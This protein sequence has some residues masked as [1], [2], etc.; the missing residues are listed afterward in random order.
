MRVYWLAVFSVV[1]GYSV[2]FWTGTFEATSVVDAEVRTAAVLQF[3]LI[4]ICKYQKK[5]L[6]ARIHL[7]MNNYTDFSCVYMHASVCG[8]RVRPF[9]C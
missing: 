6:L 5:E 3:T 2:C 7:Y 1:W 4:D 9:V 8:G